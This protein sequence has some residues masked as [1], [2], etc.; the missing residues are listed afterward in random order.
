MTARVELPDEVLGALAYLHERAVYAKSPGLQRR[1]DTLRA[2]VERVA[3]ERDAAVADARR[4][5]ALI[6]AA[7]VCVIKGTKAAG[8]TPAEQIAN[9]RVIL[10]HKGR[11]V[12]IIDTA[13]AKE[14]GK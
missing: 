8:L 11:R 9:A 12:R 2:Y 14:A 3:G 4:L 7:P 1:V 5:E 13:L 10:A 6:D